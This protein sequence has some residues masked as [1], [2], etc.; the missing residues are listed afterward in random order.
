MIKKYKAIFL[1]IASED[2]YNDQYIMKKILPEWRPL[3]PFFKAVHESYMNEREDMKMFF[4]YGSGKKSFIPQNQDLIFD[5]IKENDYPGIIAKTLGGIEYVHNNYDYDFII[6][7]NLST[8]WD[9]NRLASR[10]DALPKSGVF[11]H[12]MTTLEE[13]KQKYIAGYDMII[14]KDLIEKILPYKQEIIS[15]QVWQ[16]L[17]DLSLSLALQKQ[18]GEFID[19]HESIMYMTIDPFDE[20]KYNQMMSNCRVKNV[21]HF[22]VKNRKNRNIDK[23]IMKKLLQDI[24]GKS[25]L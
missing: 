21:D 12:L 17:E 16:N 2:E 24:Y 23:Y 15:Q 3:L 9:L 14:S 13:S 18:G 19:Q 8:F 5:S 7:T 1:F 11:G 20:E 25:I 6:R 10:L 4:L 22:R